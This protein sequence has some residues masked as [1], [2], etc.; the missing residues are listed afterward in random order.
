ML[1]H[2]KV[3]HSFIYS[4]IHSDVMQIT[5]NSELCRCLQHIL[6]SVNINA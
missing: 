3:I 2:V 1:M 6:C 4:F 5:A